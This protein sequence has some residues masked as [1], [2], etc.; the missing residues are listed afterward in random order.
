MNAETGRK[1]ER[2]A[3]DAAA[4]QPPVATPVRS[5]KEAINALYAQGGNKRLSNYL[6][7]SAKEIINA[8]GKPAGDQKSAANLHRGSVNHQT[9]HHVESARPSASALFKTAQTEPVVANDMTNAMDPLASKTTASTAKRRVVRTTATATPTSPV[10]KTSLKLGPKKSPLHNPPQSMASNTVRR[11]VRMGTRKGVTGLEQLLAGQDVLPPNTTEQTQATLKAM[12]AAVRQ[13]TSQSTAKPKLVPRPRTRAPQG[14]VQDVMRPAPQAVSAT[15]TVQ[16]S[17][18]AVKQPV[19]R[20]LDS[21]KRRFRPAPKGFTKTAPEPQ[22]EAISYTGYT[23][24]PSAEESKPPVEI[25]GLMDEEPTGKPVDGLG[26]VEDYKG[27]LTEQKVAQGSGTGKVPDNN[28]YAIKGQSPFFLKSVNV[29]KRP[30]SEAPAKRKKA[31]DT[32]GT[33]YEQPNLEPLDCKNSYA[34]EA[35]PAKATVPTKPTVIIP[36]SRR[37]KAPLICLLILTVILGAAVGAFIY[38]CFFQYME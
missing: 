16:P 30:L 24:E 13:T 36:A 38:L 32:G 12:R 10:I 23:M 31:R 20:P 8:Q 28:K 14:L 17:T 21:I 22:P 3:A 4:T 2:L 7:T 1:E 9:N 37:S 35:K 27:G 6:A 34:P 15:P 18:A 33:L 5:A 11:S 26:V 19:R 25:Y 29:E